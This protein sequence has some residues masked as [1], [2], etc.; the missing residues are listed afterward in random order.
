MNALGNVTGATTVD[1]S[2]GN[3]VTATTTGATVWTV[4]NPSSTGA[5]SFTLVL[6]NGGSQ[7]Q[8]WPSGT[9]W[10]N[11]TAPTLNSSGTDVLTFFTTDAGT[12]WLASK[13]GPTPVEQSG[14]KLFVWGHNGSGQLG[15]GTSVNRSS[16]VQ[17]VGQWSSL[18]FGDNFSLAIKSG[19]SLWGWGA[20]SSGQFGIGLTSG[21]RS[22][23]IQI[24]SGTWLMVEAGYSNVLGLKADGSLFSWGSNSHGLL[25]LGDTINRS[26]PVQI[27]GTW[28]S[29]QAFDVAAVA[30][31]ADGTMWVWG[32]G[33]DGQLGLGDVVKRSSPTQLVGNWRRIMCNAPSG[34]GFH[35]LG[36]R[37]DGTLW[38]WGDNGNGQ[39]GKSDVELRSS[40]VQ[41]GTGL[42][43][44]VTKSGQTSMTIRPDGTLWGWGASAVQGFIGAGDSIS[45]SSPIQVGADLWSVVTA[46]YNSHF[47]LRPD[48]SLFAWGYDRTIAG[49]LGLGSTIKRSSP[50]QIPG[51]WSGLNSGGFHSGA[52]K[53]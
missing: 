26:S 31:K 4:A 33:Y 14:Q 40:P 45:R 3:V 43:K 23:P 25:G 20:D 13:G 29:I 41:V 16:P 15:L 42:W 11:G 46:G 36:I 32:A 37:T 9:R 53:F 47:G 6:S 22:S 51:T 52:F 8:T 39:L 48:G 19:G 12:T 34:G 44:E 27:A 21:S 24:A 50:T 38:S 5:S 49:Y 35:M 30:Q 7:T 2:L 10:A 1:L 18:S 17:L 28:R